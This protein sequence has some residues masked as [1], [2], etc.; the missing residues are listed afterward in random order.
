[1]S[2]IFKGTIYFTDSN[3]EY[4][5]E[6]A[7]WNEFERRTERMGSFNV[8]EKDECPI[9]WDDD[10]DINFRDADQETFDK[11]FRVN[12]MTVE[13]IEAELGYKIKVVEKK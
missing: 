13:E 5:S 8:F 10:I 2:K 11:Y 7:F 9:V 12:E 4:P 6:E 1:M 3:G